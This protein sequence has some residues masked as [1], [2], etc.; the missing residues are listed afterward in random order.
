MTKNRRLSR[1][2]SL[3]FTAWIFGLASCAWGQ[4]PN[5]AGQVVENSIGMKLIYVPP[6]EFSMG[7][8]KQENDAAWV[9]FKAMINERR[10]DGKYDEPTAPEDEPVHSVK[11]TRSFYLGKFE[12]TQDEYRKVTGENPSEFSPTG[13]YREQV[14]ELKTGRLPVEMVDLDEAV[15]FCRKLSNLPAEKAAG[16]TYRLPTEAEWEY[17]CRAGTKSAFHFGESLNG[18]QAN[19]DGRHPF[20]G[21]K[22]GSFLERTTAVGSYPPNAWGFHDMHGNVEEWCSDLF[23]PDYY[24]HSPKAD[25]H[26]PTLKQLGGSDFDVALESAP[27]IR[28]GGGYLTRAAFC[29]SAARPVLYSPLASDHDASIGFRVAVTIAR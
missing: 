9:A 18:T 23:W 14:R 20:G 28:R 2:F 26:G 11:I 19:C 1:L 22:K 17:A 21:A 25:P 16:R 6:G 27:R 3:V 12:V 7:T 24:R 4:P 10:S 13:E 29:R 5:R 15:A 8:P